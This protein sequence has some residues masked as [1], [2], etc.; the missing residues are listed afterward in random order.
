MKSYDHF[1]KDWLLA[2]FA[3][4]MFF[5]CLQACTTSK[6]INQVKAKE[7][8]NINSS[9]ET[10]ATT[11]SETNTN[12]TATA[13]TVTT[14]ECDTTV[15][16]WVMINDTVSGSGIKQIIVPIK[17]KRTIIKKEVIKQQQKK[18]DQVT[19]VNTKTE[20]LKSKTELNTKDKTVERTGFPWWVYGIIAVFIL[21]A[22]AV[23]L[24][25]R[26]VF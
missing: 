4:I 21:A 14:E 12:V 19:A 3:A 22:V 5:L 13:E 26:K 15:S 23:L 1:P 6:Q 7:E 9:E 18:N 20:Q 10:K 11:Q 25:R 16:V 2:I 24:Y 8:I 17:I